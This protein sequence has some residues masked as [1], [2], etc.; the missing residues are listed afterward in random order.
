MPVIQPT[1]HSIK[2]NNRMATHKRTIE[3]RQMKLIDSFVCEKRTNS[4][5]V[6]YTIDGLFTV[7]VG[8]MVV[9]LWIWDFVVGWDFSGF[10]GSN[11]SE[12][13]D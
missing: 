13:D 1:S 8:A 10:S 7:V 6:C 11:W 4:L 2:I 9:V 3:F 12:S 5:T